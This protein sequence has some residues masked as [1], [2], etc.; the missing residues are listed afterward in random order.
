MSTLRNTR[1]ERFAQA[2]AAG[3][4][5][6]AAYIEAGYTS[7]GSAADSSASK[8]LRNHKVAARVDELKAEAAKAS[9]V[10]ATQ[11]LDEMCHLGMANILDYLTIGA[12]GLPRVDFSKM[13]RQQAAA[14][15]EIT[16]DEFTDG[17]GDDARPVRRVRFKLADK[18]AALVDLGRYF[19]L[20]KQKIDHT[21]SGPGGGPIETKSTDMIDTARRVAWLLQHALEAEGE[22]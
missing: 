11:I 12:D 7:T 10:A 17:T 19:G 16:I 2:L 20:F 15:T 18:R 1:H 13:T 22:V 6:R 4:T 5:A 9:S 21:H 3:R 14:L 8:L